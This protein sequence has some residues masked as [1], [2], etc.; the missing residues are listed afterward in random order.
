MLRECL[1]SLRASLG[2]DDELLVVD[3]ASSDARVR[4]VAE[5]HGATC[6][7]AELPG[8]S[9]ARNVGWRA[10]RH[11]VVAFV[12]DDVRV[13]PAW[14]SALG[15][16][17]ASHPSVA[18][19][20]GRIL[21]P[22]GIAW[23]DVPVSTKD[24]AEPAALEAATTGVLGHSANLAVRRHA[25]RAVGG[26]DERLGAGGEFMAAEDNDLWDRLFAAGF[27]GRYEPE[28][29]AWH[30]QW[31]T[32]RQ[33]LRLN[34]GYGYGS[35][36]RIAKLVR[37]DRRRAGQAARVAFWDWGLAD[38][39]RWLPRFRYAALF[40]LLRAIAAA[41]GLVRAL[42]VPLRLGHL[43]PGPP[44]EPSGRRDVALSV[45]MPCRDAAGHLGDALRALAQEQLDVPWEIVIA[46]NGS[47]DR[48]RDVALAFQDVL[49]IRVVDASGRRGPGFARNAG[50]AAA[51]GEHLVFLDSDDVV[52][53]GYLAR[54]LEGLADADLV[55][56]QLDGERLNPA[57]LVR[58]R[59]LGLEGGLNRSLGFLPYATSSGLGVRRRAF[60]ALDGF[61]EM[62]AGEDVD[63]CWRAQLRGM[64]LRVAPGAVLHYRFRQTRWGTFTQA[65]GYGRAQPLL[66][67]RF[68]DAGMTRR[69]VRQ[70]VRDW[71]VAVRLLVRKNGAAAPF[72][73]VYLAGLAVGR[74]LGTARYRAPYL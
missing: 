21:L 37:T 29:V 23:T 12:D 34:W 16:A 73:G 56:A 49:A 70:G 48:T 31:R 6:L 42:A 71:G 18:F 65:V 35:G 55:A 1:V 50:A 22:P 59:P 41:L 52:A 51:A 61:A 67:R 8:A 40:A 3:S 66:Y 5:E 9:R 27:V 58:S 54:M 13:L 72:E 62:R 60:E 14:A 11:D 69:G 39:S 64:T 32:R 53:P 38:V 17:F 57:W 15:R 19:V 2:P 43:A 7:R 46:D 24:A 30:E 28:A 44:P 45:V 33:L 4:A 74:A 68:R 26:F 47:R 63:L 25:L 36:A 10:A 20:T